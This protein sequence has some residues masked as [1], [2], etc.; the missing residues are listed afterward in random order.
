MIYCPS[1]RDGCQHYTIVEWI[2]VS[3]FY[4][5]FNVMLTSRLNFSRSEKAT[6]RDIIAA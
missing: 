3:M 1:L 5:P 2:G 6:F 4:Y